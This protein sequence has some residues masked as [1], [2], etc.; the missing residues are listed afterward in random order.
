M[1]KRKIS[2][3][4]LPE[5]CVW[6]GWRRKDNRESGFRVVSRETGGVSGDGPVA[7]GRE[8]GGWEGG[9]LEKTLP[10]TSG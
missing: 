6:S 10:R 8:R 9:L 1:E 2:L 7:A 4:D 5:G 3:V